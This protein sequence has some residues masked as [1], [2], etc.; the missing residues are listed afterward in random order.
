M[1]LKWWA[2]G[3]DMVNS[4]VEPGLTVERREREKKNYL[5][6]VRENLGF[7]Q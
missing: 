1:D 7:G 3:N 4:Q 6:D 2:R 5:P